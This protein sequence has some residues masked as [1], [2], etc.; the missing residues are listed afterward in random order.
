MKKRVLSSWVA[1]AL[2]GGVILLGCGGE[3]KRE[4]TKAQDDIR[5]LAALPLEVPTPPDNLPS[6]EKA[7]LGKLLFFDPILS[8]HKDVACATCH[9]PE[10]GFAESLEISIGANGRGAG[11]RRTF[12]APNDIPFVKRN[13]QTVL[14]AA[15]NGLT[16]TAAADPANA[17]MFWDVRVR[18]LEK[19]S[20]EPIKAL[21][22][23]RGH[24]YTSEAA[25]D[26][27]VNRLKKI[28]EYQRLF[29]EAF[30]M[31]S[32]IT[33]ENMARALAAY[34]RTLVGGNSRFDRYLRGDKSAL[35]LNELDGMQ[36]FLKSGCAQCHNG[37]MLSDFKLHTLGVSDNE[38]LAQTD[39]GVDNQYK[40]RTPS[41]RNLR[42]TAPYMHS[43]KLKTLEQVLEFYE[44]LAGDKI[45]NPHVTKTQLDPIVDALRV[46]FKDISL[47]VEF[48]NTL[49]DDAFDRTLP[50]K[51]PSGLTPGG[52]LN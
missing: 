13:S 12:N 17:P 21:E 33:A 41:L 8:G 6:A 36:A 10:F 49:N 26:S 35:S 4:K 2:W 37:P 40:F 20:L 32:P 9:H 46:D 29:K 5:K 30:P 34:E 52:N 39:A 28:G 15:F 24:R 7:A 18:S 50:A 38:K 45:R 47:I 23:M 27:V 14:N 51:V 19:Q 3:K 25:L 43:G 1:V 48:L 22:E 16:L 11:S 42:Y 31:D 44:D